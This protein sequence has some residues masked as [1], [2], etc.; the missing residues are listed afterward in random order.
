MRL[1]Y[2]RRDGQYDRL[3]VEK[4]RIVSPQS[5]IKAFAAM[6][7]DEPHTSTKNYKSLRSRVGLTIFAK[8]DRLEPYHVA[9][10]AAYKLEQQ[11]RSHKLSPEYKSARYHILLAV[12]LLVDASPLP[13][14]N[15]HEMERRCGELLQRLSDPESAD[16]LFQAA[17]GIIDAVSGK[18]LNREIIRTQAITQA[19]QS[20]FAKTVA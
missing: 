12:R 16:G 19:I 9:A 17:K 6:F 1:Y 2:E 7:L 14:L 15:S 18:N 4:S 20:M 10:F 13:R 3:P 5:V 8:D 11:Y